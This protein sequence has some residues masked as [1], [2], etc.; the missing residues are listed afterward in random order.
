MIFNL[1]NCLYCCYRGVVCEPLF[2]AVHIILG[3]N[4]GSKFVYWSKS[5]TF[6]MVNPFFQIDRLPI[7]IITGKYS[8]NLLYGL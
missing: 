6:V 4:N 8:V 3:G 5:G 7:R 1:L 2:Q